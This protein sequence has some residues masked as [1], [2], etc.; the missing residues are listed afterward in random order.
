MLHLARALHLSAWLYFSAAVALSYLTYL[1]VNPLKWG[2]TYEV[3]VLEYLPF[4]ALLLASAVAL[5]R[6]RRVTAATA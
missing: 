1:D 3:R 5:W 6:V 4:Y 2:E